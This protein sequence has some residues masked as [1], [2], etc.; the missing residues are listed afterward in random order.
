M[1]NVNQGMK[2]LN[3]DLHQDLQGFSKVMMS[4]MVQSVSNAVDF[5]SDMAHD[6]GDDFEQVQAVLSLGSIYDN[7]VQ[8]FANEID[9]DT[10][11]PEHV[12]EAVC[13]ALKRLVLEKVRLT[14]E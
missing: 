8:M 2:M 10:A 1:H 3:K 6:A 9:P 12:S 4:L 5:A 11:N 13:K 14:V 7:S